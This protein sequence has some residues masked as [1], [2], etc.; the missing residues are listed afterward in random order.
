MNR[1]RLQTLSILFMGLLLCAAIVLYDQFAQTPIQLYTVESS[2]SKEEEELKL[3]LNSANK[4]ELMEIKGIGE[5]IAGR[6]IEYR[7]K[8]GGFHYL[9][10]LLEI[11]GIGQAKYESLKDRLC[12]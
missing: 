6:I 11:E 9:E 10:E 2:L 4:E 1:E 8:H 12:L 7:L 5:A 3:N